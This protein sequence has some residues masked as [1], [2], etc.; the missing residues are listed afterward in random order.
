M[1]EIANVRVRIA[2][3]CIMCTL[4][5]FSQAVAQN[6][7]SGNLKTTIVPV[8]NFSQTAVIPYSGASLSRNN[9]ALF[10]T[11]STAQ[12]TP[13]TVVSMWWVIFNNPR[14]CAQGSCSVPDLFNPLVNAS[15]QNAGARIVGRDGS[16]S[17]GAY[18]A[19]GDPTGGHVLPGMPDP[20]RGLLNP[21][22]ATVHLV[23]RSHGPASPDPATLSEQLTL[24]N[25]GCPPN[26]CTN[27]QAAVFEP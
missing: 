9:D 24:F 22:G 13:D 11:L 18:L 10:A 6:S 26:T 2:F 4:A 17:F 12:L 5:F 14:A 27:I 23:L 16:A 15:L 25:G 19:I 8:K 21:K 3:T 7:G 20:S 1:K